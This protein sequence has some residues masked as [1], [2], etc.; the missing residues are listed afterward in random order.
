MGTMQILL[1]VGLTLFVLYNVGIFVI[2]RGRAP[3]SVSATSYI[4]QN[5]LGK[6]Y[7]L[8]FTLICMIVAGT[9]LPLWME[10]TPDNLQF[11]VFLACAGVLFAG[12]TPFFREGLDRPIHYTSGIITA[13]AYILWFVFVGDCDWLFYMVCAIVITCLVVWSSRVWLYFVE[14]YG[15]ITLA[16]YL[17]NR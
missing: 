9:F 14:L 7:S 3:G 15:L 2:N 1:L 11:L 6:K 5:R 8:L 12:S 17:I 16:I 13:I 4:L 10:S